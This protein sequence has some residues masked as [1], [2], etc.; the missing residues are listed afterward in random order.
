[1]LYEIGNEG[2]LTSVRWQYHFI[3][4]IQQYEGS[5]PRQ[6]PVG[7]TAVFNIISGTWATE[8]RVLFESPADWI[9]PGLSSY[10][11]N[12]P[13]A[14]GTKIIIADVDHI[15]PAAPHRSWVWKCFLRG[16]HPILMD[17]YSY[18]E[19]KWTSNAEQEAMRKYMGYTLTYANKM[20]L[21]AMTPRN[22]LSSTG[23]CLAHPGR[24][25]LVYQPKAGET[26]SVE[27]PAGTYNYEW[28]N[29]AE[30]K[31]AG[32]G[33]VQ[34]T[35]DGQQFKTSFPPCQRRCGRHVAAGEGEAVLYL[36]RQ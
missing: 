13:A 28:F 30:G 17:W 36:K 9:S 33:N 24:E 8:N 35:G 3:R 12:P 6:H 34:T 15:W 26:F 5:K 2:D 20:N 31:D 4:F 21:A 1:M 29:P 25:Y 22:E 23:Y 19:P 7:M 32:S 16:I 11:D 14:D 27:L 18:G 10:K